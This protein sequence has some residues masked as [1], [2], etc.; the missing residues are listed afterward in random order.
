MSLEHWAW[1]GIAAQPGSKIVDDILRVFPDP[2]EFFLS[3]DSGIE[4]VGTI[5]AI[6]A[7]RIRAT[8]L[9]F[10]KRAVETAENYGAKVIT[11]ESEFY[12]QNLLSIKSAPPVLY[13]L[14]D[15][16]CLNQEPAVAV[17]GTR[18][19]SE[20]GNKMSQIIA[21]GLGSAGALVVSG[22]ALGIDSAAHKACLSAGGKTVAVQGCG[23]CKTFPPENVELK[24]LI[25]A[26]GAV[27]SEFVPDAEAAGSFFR[28]ATESF[29][30]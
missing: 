9:D 11:K 6:D 13:V 29:P 10:A 25:A 20:Y 30:E 3:G 19:I 24:E 7:L 12:P 23:I 15:E 8:S 26:N 5:N 18:R 1:L 27:I 21:G 17:V 14:G 28:F 2:E 4:K 22:M 16:T